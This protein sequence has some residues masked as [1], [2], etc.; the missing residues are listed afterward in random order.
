MFKEY[1]L[2]QKELPFALKI[3]INVTLILTVAFIIKICHH[4]Y[5]N[6][7]NPQERAVIRG[8]N[9]AYKN[10]QD[11]L[12][13]YYKKNNYK[14][15]QSYTDTNRDSICEALSEKFSKL[16]GEC[17]HKPNLFGYQK[18]FTF[19]DTNIEVWGLDMQ[20][21]MEDGAYI[22]EFFIDA[23]GPKGENRFG[24]DRIPLKMYLT[25]RL[26]GLLSP[27]NCSKE[28]FDDFSF[29]LSSMCSSDIQVDYL[30]TNKYFGYDIHQVGGDLGKT[31]ALNR[32]V[33]FLRADCIAF[34]GELIAQY[35]FCDARM[36]P[37]LPACYDEFPCAMEL[38]KEK[39]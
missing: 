24:V 15:Q 8:V 19:N 16:G 21:K 12:Q 27:V 28:H 25:G 26:S 38:A 2:K 6:V 18:N 3:T 35:E 33:S 4:F 34:G 10:I 1:E 30:D 36:Y 17:E 11:E 9:Y 23:D 32:N 5:Y 14:F 37:W 7:Y 31:R 39:L 22:K 20:P 29:P 13:Q